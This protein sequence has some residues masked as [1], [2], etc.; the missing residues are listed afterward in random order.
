MSDQPVLT[1]AAA[2]VSFRNDLIEGGYRP[3]EAAGLA[4]AALHEIVQA[5]GICIRVEASK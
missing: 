1:T 2:L 4:S 3:E 5:L